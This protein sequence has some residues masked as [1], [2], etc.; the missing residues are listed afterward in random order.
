MKL[1][2]LPVYHYS[3]QVGATEDVEGIPDETPEKR[4]APSPDTDAPTPL[5]PPDAVDEPPAKD[6]SVEPEIAKLD[7]RANR[8]PSKYHI[9][10]PTRMKT[11]GKRT[12][13]LAMVQDYI[14]FSPERDLL[15]VK[16][17][18]ATA[19]ASGTP[20]R[21]HVV[22]DRKHERKSLSPDKRTSSPDKRTTSPDSKKS[23]V[24]SSPE[25]SRV[26][27]TPEVPGGD[28]DLDGE[29]AVYAAMVIS[30]TLEELQK[31]CKPCKVS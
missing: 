17:K 4:V 18:T 2:S 1:E 26:S 24:T 25:K 30:G 5:V 14:E 3:L 7:M 23:S 12:D 16:P 8:P 10:S 21:K 19:H 31:L 22:S 29:D 6:D 27:P 9:P 28:L 20:D 11:R 15:P 13:V